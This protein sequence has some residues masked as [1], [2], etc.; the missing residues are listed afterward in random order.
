MQ[1]SL[2]SALL[3]LA[4]LAGC[5]T[6]AGSSGSSSNT[7][8]SGEPI[9]H[10][11]STVERARSLKV[12]SI[13]GVTHPTNLVDNCIEVFQ[14]DAE[15]LRNVAV[16]VERQATSPISPLEK[17]TLVVEWKDYDTGGPQ[18][19]S[20]SGIL[21]LNASLPL[22]LPAGRDATI[23]A[24]V[25]IETSDGLPVANEEILMTLRATTTMANEMEISDSEARVCGKEPTRI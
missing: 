21:P 16:K 10:Q 2:A 1:V 9:D 5:A 3:V 15:N 4:F 13:P 18:M 20:A 24:Y 12:T 25:Q 22:K 7:L 14:H 6:P 8:G 17:F 19:S 11:A 23:S